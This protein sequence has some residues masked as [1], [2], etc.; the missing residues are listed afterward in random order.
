MIVFTVEML[1]IFYLTLFSSI[2]IH[3]LGHYIFGLLTGYSVYQLKIFGF[4]I[5]ENKKIKCK[6]SNSMPKNQCLMVPDK[7]EKF[8]YILYNLGGILANLMIVVMSIFIL[9][10]G[11]YGKIVAA[12]LMMSIVFNLYSFIVNGIPLVISGLPNDMKNI[13]L[14][15]SS[16]SAKKAFHSGF[17]IDFYLKQ[18]KELKEIDSQYFELPIDYD[19][20]NIY[21]AYNQMQWAINRIESGYTEEGLTILMNLS[22]ELS[23]YKKYLY[24]YTIIASNIIYYSYLNNEN[25]DS[26][27]KIYNDSKFAKYG[28]EKK[29]IEY[30]LCELAYKTHNRID[31]DKELKICEEKV[32][33]AQNKGL[34]HLYNKQLHSLIHM[35]K[36]FNAI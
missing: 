15:S 4:I 23:Y 21:V 19:M 31:F 2:I 33:I 10:S 30:Y 27:N 12:I 18:G 9:Q 36:I 32:T 11:N 16:P 28:N 14:V 26:A 3:E 25:I 13:I 24:Y 6:K 7:Y 20:K 17:M 34:K 22:E 35:E 29:I 1:I 5:I 8:S